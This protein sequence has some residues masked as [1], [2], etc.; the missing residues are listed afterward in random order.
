METN[1]CIPQGYRL[2]EFSE[3]SENHLGKPQINVSNNQRHVTEIYIGF[4][5][6]LE[7]VRVLTEPVI[8]LIKKISLPPV[9]KKTIT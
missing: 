5:V 2:I 6:Y 3:L 4:I 9:Q 1:R 8:G 7:F